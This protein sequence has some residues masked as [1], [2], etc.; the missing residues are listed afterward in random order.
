M[1]G[2]DKFAPVFAAIDEHNYRQAMKLLEKR[3]LATTSLGKVRGGSGR[4]TS[5]SRARD[6]PSTCDA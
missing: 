6:R 4:A 1:S 2:R 5:P 3:E